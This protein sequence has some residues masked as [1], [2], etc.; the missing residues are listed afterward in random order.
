MHLA[1]QAAMV[2]ALACLA[3]TA[4]E[5]LATWRLAPSWKLLG[6]GPGAQVRAAVRVLLAL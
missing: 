1:Q 2:V 4:G 6:L 3:L 5:E